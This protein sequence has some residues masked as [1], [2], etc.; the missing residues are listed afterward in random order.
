[1]MWK[2]S[3]TNKVIDGYYW[4]RRPRGTAVRGAKVTCTNDIT[5]YYIRVDGYWEEITKDEIEGMGYHYRK[6]IRR[7]D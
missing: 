4:E 1:M 2:K 5:R 7:V 3:F 6:N